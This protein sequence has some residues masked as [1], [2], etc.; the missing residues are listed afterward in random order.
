MDAFELVIE[1]DGLFWPRS[2]VIYVNGRRLYDLASAAASDP[3]EE[4]VE[5]ARF[6]GQAR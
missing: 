4:W 6:D 3:D 1:D 5:L 2:A